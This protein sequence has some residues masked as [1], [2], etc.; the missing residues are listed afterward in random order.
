MRPGWMC[1]LD[2]C[3]PWM[4]NEFAARHFVTKSSF[5]HPVHGPG[6]ISDCRI[7]SLCDQ[8]RSETLGE[9]SGCSLR[10]TC[11][12]TTETTETWKE[13]NS[14]F[15]KMNI[16]RKDSVYKKYQIRFGVWRKRDNVRFG[17]LKAP[18]L[19]CIRTDLLELPQIL[20]YQTGVVY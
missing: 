14:T 10:D 17:A 16:L 20:R 15:V 5:A 9:Y 2:E 12:Q 19:F 13:P 8:F 7:V 6:S 18:S 1:T 4:C 11:L 3:G